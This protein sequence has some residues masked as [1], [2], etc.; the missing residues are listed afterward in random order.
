[1]EAL[2]HIR[3]PIRE[4]PIGRLM[5]LEN[6][7]NLSQEP[8]AVPKEVWLLVDRLYRH[9]IKTVGLF[10]TPGLHSEIIA[11][12]DWLDN[13]SQDPMPGS[14]H[15]V[16]EALL[17]LLESTAEPLIPYNLHSVC[18]S[19]ATNYLQCKQ[20]VMQLPEIRRTVFLYICYF[21]QELLNH[22]QDNELDVKL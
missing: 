4:I 19:A 20:I 9:G 1:M 17:L 21:L 12:R 11:I 13:G 8:Y 18:L 7:K 3:V 15:S 14:V 10:E 2:V 16:A 22:I 5:E 6:N